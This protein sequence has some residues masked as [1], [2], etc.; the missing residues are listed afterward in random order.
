MAAESSGHFPQF[1]LDQLMIARIDFV[2][3][4]R[5]RSTARRTLRFIWQWVAAPAFLAASLGFYY[6]NTQE[7]EEPRLVRVRG[8][9]AK[10][11]F[12]VESNWTPVTFVDPATGELYVL[13][14]RKTGE[15]MKED[16]TDGN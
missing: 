10:Q 2:G 12:R 15:S 4:R 13:V 9:I 1:S 6:I 3:E 11:Y 8:D 5:G 14:A 16:K 7:R